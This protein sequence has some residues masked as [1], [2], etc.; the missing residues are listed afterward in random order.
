MSIHSYLLPGNEEN[1]LR[2]LQ[3]LDVLVAFTDPIFKEFADLAAHIFSLPISFISA[4]GGQQVDF[5]AT[6]GI[7]ELNMLPREQALCSLPVKHSSTIVLNKI[8][9]ASASVHQRTAEALGLDFYVGSPLLLEQGVAV[10]ALCICDK[11]PREFSQQE[12]QVLEQLARLI[13]RTISVRY[14]CLQQSDGKLHWAT[15]QNNA[16]EEIRALEGL[17]RYIARRYDLRVPTP[18][19][20]LNSVSRRLDDIDEILGMEA[21]ESALA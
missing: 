11:V 3:K 7:P 2:I 14:A 1:R 19:T 12:Q 15:V 21:G 8:L 13:S 18:A 16:T 20:I 17:I 5:V 9:T 4:V 6:H 10:G